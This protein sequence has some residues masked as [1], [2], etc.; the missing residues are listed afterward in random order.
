MHKF[1]RWSQRFDP[2]VKVIKTPYQSLEEMDRLYAY[3]VDEEGTPVCFWK[4]KVRDFSDRNCRLRWYA[5]T[6][7]EFFGKV[8]QA[9]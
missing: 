4:G 5:L 7:D 9:Y 2:E 1:N 3:L 8:T 6:N